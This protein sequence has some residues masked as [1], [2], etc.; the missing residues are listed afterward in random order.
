MEF[1]NLDSLFSSLKSFGNF[2]P[3]HDLP[4][5]FHKVWSNILVVNVVSML[6]DIDGEK[7]D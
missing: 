6:P 5:F 1:M 2:S 4:D 3:V 7:R